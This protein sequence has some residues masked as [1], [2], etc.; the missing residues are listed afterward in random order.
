MLRLSRHFVERWKERVG[1]DAKPDTVTKIVRSPETVRVQG[2]R[3]L[4]WLNG[5]M[6]R[7][8]AIYWNPGWN[9]VIKV[10]EFQGVAVTVL[11]PK[12]GKEARSEQ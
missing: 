2:C 12:N 7:Q 9:V 8:L 4:Q 10:D 1:S 11:S 3:N 6:F 5:D